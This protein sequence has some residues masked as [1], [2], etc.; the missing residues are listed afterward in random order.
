MQRLGTQFIG[1]F[2]IELGMS[3][4]ARQDTCLRLT[5]D[6]RSELPCGFHVAPHDR[7]G[8]LLNAAIGP[9]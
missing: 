3:P 8:P 4:A 1:S 7:N 2:Q 5:W 9:A 6:Q